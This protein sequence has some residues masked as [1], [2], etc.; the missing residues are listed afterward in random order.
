MNKLN[1]C[2]LSK[3]AILLPCLAV[4]TLFIGF[5]SCKSATEELVAPNTALNSTA[6]STELDTRAGLT[7]DST[8]TV[9]E[10]LAAETEQSRLGMQFQFSD[11]EPVGF[12]LPAGQSVTLKVTKLA[13]TRYPKLIIGTL[14][15]AYS[16]ADPY[17]STVGSVQLVEGTNTI[18]N[19]QDVGGLLYLKYAVAT[20]PNSAATVKFVSGMKSV[21]FYKQGKTTNAQWLQMLTTFNTV[22]DVQL[23]SKR[24]IIVSSLANATTYK[25]E[26]QDLILQHIDNVF[27][28]ESQIAGLDNSAPQHAPSTKRV[29]IVQHS[30]LNYY[31]YSFGGR[32]AIASGA[33]N[34]VL[35]VNGIS[36]DGWGPWHEIGHAF[37]QTWKWDALGE[38]TT[39]IYSLKVQ[40]SYGIASRLKTDNIWP[41]ATTFFAQ[42]D[43]TRDFNAS[44]T[45]VWVR[46][47]LFQQL[48]LAFGDKFYQDQHKAYRIEKPVLTTEAAKM[49]WFMLS[50]CKASGKNLG[51]FFKKWGFKVDASVYAEIN[52]LNLP[53][54]TVDP[55]T[56]KD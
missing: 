34:S 37:Q 8:F 3:A 32:I 51:N 13:G 9:S 18:T 29:L 11:L 6:V 16:V 56:L 28:Q 20:A 45:N 52:A 47:C 5:S 54:P 33:M 2:F 40:R 44:T 48:Y 26:N 50:A 35:T 17:G 53:L 22:P 21:P 23:V 38:V 24:G 43:A 4:S 27:E 25:T 15:R 12:Y 14:S 42:P 31:M 46:L 55:T 36:K 41:N 19:P 1:I 49:R 39:N 7:I 10:V 30:N